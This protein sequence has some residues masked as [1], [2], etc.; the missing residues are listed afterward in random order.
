[1]LFLSLK[2]QL[3]FCFLV[4]KT[5]ARVSFCARKTFFVIKRLFLRFKHFFCARKTFFVL[6]RLFL[7]SKKF[8][9]SRP[10]YTINSTKISKRKIYFYFLRYSNNFYLYTVPCSKKFSCEKSVREIPK[11]PNKTSTPTR[12][13]NLIFRFRKAK[14]IAFVAYLFWSMYVCICQST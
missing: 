14:C 3:P 10:P 1:M 8:C 13:P 5:T 2:R 6:E 7:L 9:N 11:E 12:P 4:W